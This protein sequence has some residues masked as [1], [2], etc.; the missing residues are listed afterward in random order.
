M[1]WTGPVFLLLEEAYT[2]YAEPAP[3]R[4]D[5][6]L[7]ALPFRLRD[8][9]ASAP[10]DWLFYEAPGLLAA[11]HKVVLDAS[12]CQHLGTTLSDGLQGLL[13][14][15]ARITRS[16]PP[17]LVILDGLGHHLPAVDLPA[18]QRAAA[19]IPDLTL[20]ALTCAPSL[21]GEA[22]VRAA[23]QSDLVLVHELVR[24]SEPRLADLLRRDRP[25]APDAA[26]LST[27]TGPVD[28]RQWSVL[29]RYTPV[30]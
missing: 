28:G 12:W 15:L 18:V 6:L 3:S 10:G 29:P 21:L 8:L 25:G 1:H 17:I 22:W 26:Y 14:E 30:P 13:H 2:G 4:S 19:L 7:D 20:L 5:G 24:S 11:G 27:G 23:A 9:P 16:G